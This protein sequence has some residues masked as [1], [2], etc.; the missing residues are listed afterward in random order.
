MALEVPRVRPPGLMAIV[1]A[2]RGPAGVE[3]ARG[4]WLSPCTM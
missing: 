3:D 1:P 4:V 2:G